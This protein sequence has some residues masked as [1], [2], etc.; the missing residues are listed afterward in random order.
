VT[1][2]Q[3]VSRLIGLTYDAAADPSLWQTTLASTLDVLDGRAGHLLMIEAGGT[4]QNVVG[5]NFEPSE[6]LKY[7]VYYGQLDP[8]APLLETSPVGTIVTCRDV[9][10]LE[11]RKKEF[12]SEWATPNEGADAV[13][14]NLERTGRS[15]C[16]LVL[17][18]PW[19]SK[20]FGTPRMLRTL[21][22]LIPHFQRAMA[23]RHALANATQYNASATELIRTQHGCVLLG[24]D[25]RVLYANAAARHMTRHNEGLTLAGNGLHARTAR[26]EMLLQHLI[27]TAQPG[28]ADLARG[29]GRMSIERG[30]GRSPVI[31]QTLP[32]SSHWLSQAFPGCTLVLIIDGERMAHMCHRALQELFGLTPAEASVAARIPGSRGLQT[33][34]NEMGL[35]LSTVRTHLQRAFEKTGTHRQAELVQL[36]SELSLMGDIFGQFGAPSQRT[37]V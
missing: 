4:R 31:V 15:V 24:A 36:L 3:D 10:P 35:G 7:N 16:A 26:D 5:A 20:P 19:L 37:K 25:G 2:R 28:Y 8:V 34:A 21:E 32:L 30:R 1:L 11:E 33:L 17:A 18:R 29:G 6:T 27:R 9:V 14:V 13:F 22:F 23:S 12:Y